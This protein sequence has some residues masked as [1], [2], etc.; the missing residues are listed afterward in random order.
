VGP[1][2]DGAWNYTNNQK[3]IDEFWREGMERDKN[4]EEVVTLGMRGHGDTPMSADANIDLLER[5]VSDQ[6]EFSSRQST[7]T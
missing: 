2:V 1:K 4:Y 6:R 3:K 7:P 5:V